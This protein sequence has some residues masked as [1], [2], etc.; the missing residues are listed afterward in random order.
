M[1]SN[2]TEASKGQMTRHQLIQVARRLFSEH[3]YHN[4]ALSDIQQATGLTKG[5]FYHHFQS[6]QELALA[7]LEQA[8]RDYE[9]ALIAPAMKE[10]TP[11]RQLA[12]LLH[13]FVRLYHQPDW[14]NCLMM[15]TLSAELNATDAT[16]H[17][18]VC[19]MHAEMLAMWSECILAAQ[20]HGEINTELSAG[21]L[22]RWIMSTMMG[23]LLTGKLHGDAADPDAVI[24]LFKDSLLRR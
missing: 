17:T 21:T 20:K 22:A 5:A 2:S 11:G 19:D 16:L 18:A 10:K 1:S 15:T 8:R 24:E 12:A 14:S 3:G 13:G 7:I 4:T 23:L 6:K 9:E